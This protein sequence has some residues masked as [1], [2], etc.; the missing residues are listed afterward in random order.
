MHPLDYRSSLWSFVVLNFFSLRMIYYDYFSINYFGFLIS[1]IFLSFSFDDFFSSLCFFS[2]YEM[3][4]YIDKTSDKLVM[5]N[6]F[7]FFCLIS[8]H[9]NCLLIFTYFVGYCLRKYVRG[10][11]GTYYYPIPYF[12]RWNLSLMSLVKDLSYWIDFLNTSH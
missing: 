8:L 4:Y 9:V 1:L 12:C 11:Y 5:S 3:I 6:F 7:T 2:F 10:L